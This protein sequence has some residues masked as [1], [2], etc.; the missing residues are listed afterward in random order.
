MPTTFLAREFSTSPI[1]QSGLEIAKDGRF[2][3]LANL[4]TLTGDNPAIQNN[5]ALTFTGRTNANNI[6]GTGTLNINGM[7]TNEAKIEQNILLIDS[8]NKPTSL[9]TDAGLL[10]IENGIDNTGT[11]T[12]TGGDNENAITNN[13]TM[14]YQGTGTNTGA[15]SGSMGTLNITGNIT[16]NATIAQKELAIAGAG[17]DAG[18]SAGSLTTNAGNLTITNGITNNGTLTFTGG[19]NA[20]NIFGTGS[21]EIIGDVTNAD[22]AEIKQGELEIAEND[23]SLTTNADNLILADKSITNNGLLIFTGGTNN[24]AVSGN[25]SVDIIGSVTNTAKIEQNVTISANTGNL[26]N[27]ADISGTVTNAGKLANSGTLGSLDNQSGAEAFNTGTISGTVT[28]AGTLDNTNGTISGDVTNSGTL[29]SAAEN[30]QSNIANNAGGTLNL[31]GTLGKD[32]SGTG[33]TN[34]NGTLA[35]E[36]NADIEGTLNM[37]GGTLDLSKENTDNDD[38]STEHN[39]GKLTGTGTIQIDSDMSGAGSADKL[40]VGADSDA[41]VT[42]DSINITKEHD[43]TFPSEDAPEDK[44][45]QVIG[46]DG[47][48]S[49]NL[50]VADNTAT[51]TSD[52]YMYKFTESEKEGH[53]KV[54]FD[55][56]TA[57]LSEFMT[58]PIPIP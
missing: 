50:A 16:N 31:S 40:I 17:S 56:T 43:T 15:I 14:E 49:V 9:T 42:I 36:S 37:N 55:R 48:G 26:T 8:L 28:N 46:G 1:K 30:L 24:N 13:G 54:D 53:I 3:T 45:I 11:L 39:I 52:H 34:I 6:S 33:T 32:V 51:L 27:S 23:D 57:G 19:E 10:D 18:T 22:T 25:G 5:G 4:I 41:S 21:L 35:F 7:V 58:S 12:F 38:K 2:K 47:A 44:H 29:T 20:N